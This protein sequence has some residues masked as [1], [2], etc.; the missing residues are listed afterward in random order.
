MAAA[1]L[2]EAA[3]RRAVDAEEL[4]G[5]ADRVAV[6]CGNPRRRP[7]APHGERRPALRRR[8]VVSP[9]PPEAV[10]EHEGVEVAVAVEVGELD[11]AAVFGGED[12]GR[13]LHREA[14]AVARVPPDPVSPFTSE[15]EVHVAVSVEVAVGGAVDAQAFGLG[16]AVREVGERED[17][18]F[19]LERDAV[20]RRGFAHPAAVG[21]EHV[22]PAVAVEVAGERA[23]AVAL[24]GGEVE[25]GL[26]DEGGHGVLHQ[27][28]PSSRRR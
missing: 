5:G 3:E 13:L 18:V 26:A 14:V 11:G 15:E 4:N 16:V 10:A 24:R 21:M 28:T 25:R 8:D 23:A 27:F 17:A 9:H 6:L 2:A 19:E 22:E 20:R 1:D 12:H 7:D